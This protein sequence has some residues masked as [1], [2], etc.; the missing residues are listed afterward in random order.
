MWFGLNWWV[1]V[2]A[3]LDNLH[4]YNYIV[5]QGRAELGNS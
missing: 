5:I 2:C 3:P 4:K 1:F